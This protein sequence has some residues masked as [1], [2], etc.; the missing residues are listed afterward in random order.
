LL[1]V[2]PL[3]ALAGGR[4][5]LRGH[6]QE[7]VANWRLMPGCLLAKAVVAVCARSAVLRRWAPA[8]MSVWALLMVRA[9]VL[10][11][12]AVDLHLRVAPAPLCLRLVLHR[13]GLRRGWSSLLGWARL[14]RQAL[15]LL[16]LV[17]LT[18]PVAPGVLS[19]L[20]RAVLLVALGLCA[21]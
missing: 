16:L 19:M 15:C 5:L 12:L 6:R 21:S 10:L 17:T 4:T 14:V 13:R 7:L 9:R 20:L 11:R 2:A 18:T 3:L 8:V 1:L